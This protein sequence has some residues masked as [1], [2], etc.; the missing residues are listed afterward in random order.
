MQNQLRTWWVTNPPAAAEHKLVGSV[1]EALLELRRLANHDLAR[2][3]VQ[4]NAGGLEIFDE[5]EWVEWFNE[6]GDDVCVVRDRLIAN[7]PDFLPPYVAEAPR[8]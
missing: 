1:A 2:A 7:M 3:S 5:G 8:S 4:A 6:D